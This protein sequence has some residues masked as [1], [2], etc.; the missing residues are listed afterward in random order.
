MA[1]VVSVKDARNRDLRVLFDTSVLIPAWEEG[2][3]DLDTKAAFLRTPPDLRSVHE[4]VVWEFLRGKDLTKE[5]RES[6]ARWLRDQSVRY[7]VNP[8]A[9][10]LE[11]LQSLVARK[12]ARGSPVDA[13]LAACS[14]ASRGSIVIATGDAD[15]FCWHP[16]I[17]IVEEFIKAGV[18][19]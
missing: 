19:G 2:L 12:E 9:K 10:A 16:D 11:T 1:R 8:P 6:R 3:R 17:W 18:C 7:L 5:K 13:M 14:I 4:L 15:D